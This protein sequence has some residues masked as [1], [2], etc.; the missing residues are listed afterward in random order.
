MD[1]A[2]LQPAL[3]A[4]IAARAAADAAEL[5][6]FQ[7]V[8]ALVSNADK[9]APPVGAA[10]L[11]PRPGGGVYVKALI[12]LA[13]S[14]GFHVGE[15]QFAAAVVAIAAAVAT[16]TPFEVALAKE[17]AKILPGPTTPPAPPAPPDP[18]ADIPFP[19]VF[20]SDAPPA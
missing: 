20:A 16:G 15:G 8:K 18:N 2:S 19:G 17:L 6:F 3:D 1:L 9:L 13:R 12:A 14:V 10:P 11:L 4:A 7:A 5:D